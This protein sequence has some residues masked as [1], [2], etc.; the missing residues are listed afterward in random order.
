MPPSARC[1]P[2]WRNMT[3]RTVL[4]ISCLSVSLLVLA[5]CGSDDSSGTDASDPAAGDDAT[6]IELTDFHGRA[7][8]L[9]SPVSASV[10]LV[11]NAMNTMYAVGGGSSIVG[12]GDIWQ[13]SFKEAFF[14]GVQPGF[15]DLPVVASNDGLYDLE[16]V[17]QLNPDFVVLWAESPDD[18]AIEAIEDG[19]DVPVYAVFLRSFDDLDKL[20]TDLAAAAGN[21]AR[22]IEVNDLVSDTLDRIQEISDQIDTAD[23]P[24]VYWMWGDVFGTAGTESSASDLIEIA[25]GV[26][27]VSEMVDGDAT[28]EQPVLS[29]EQIVE[30]NPDVIYMWFNPDID[31]SDVM[32]G[33]TVGTTDF[34]TWQGLDAVQNGLVFE[35][36]DPFMYDFMTGRTPIAALKV[37][38]DINAEAF[39]GWDL[40]AE[41][42][43]YFRAMYGVGYPGF[44]PES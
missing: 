12:T 26:N 4:L 34:S 7:M 42:D 23:K 20:T 41:Y 29:M 31:P 33:R 14:E 13:P 28:Q 10:F 1:S 44:E 40:S 30:L 37:A 22:G 5:S 27:V 11:E 38:K 17:A 43:D 32:E 24:S 21:P 36:D 15:S 16:A 39:D 3:S 6:S 19:L 35:L 9:D 8:T 18:K 2:Q 25:G